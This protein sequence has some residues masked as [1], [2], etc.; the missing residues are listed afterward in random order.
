MKAI[1][2]GEEMNR[3][4]WRNLKACFM[5]FFLGLKRESVGYYKITAEK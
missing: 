2:K 1:I 5:I 4:S 3:Q